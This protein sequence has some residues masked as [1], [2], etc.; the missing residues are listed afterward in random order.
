M[1]IVYSVWSALYTSHKDHVRLYACNP[2]EQPLLDYIDKRQSRQVWQ[3]ENY[4]HRY[5]GHTLVSW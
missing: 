4:Q 5:K 2:P 1:M 3:D